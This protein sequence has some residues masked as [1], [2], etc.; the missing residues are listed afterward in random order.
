[1][2]IKIKTLKDGNLKE[3]AK[4]RLIQSEDERNSENEEEKSD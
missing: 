4:I 2:K 1:M 3:K